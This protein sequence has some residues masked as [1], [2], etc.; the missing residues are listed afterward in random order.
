[1]N[2]IDV[3]ARKERRVRLVAVAFY[4]IIRQFINYCFDVQ[5]F[6]RRICPFVKDHNFDESR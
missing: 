3:V 2:T 1:M 5:V 4:Q 6:W